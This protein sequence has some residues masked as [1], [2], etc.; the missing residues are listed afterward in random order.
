MVEGAASIFTDL[1]V[2]EACTIEALLK[3]A[4]GLVE[5]EGDAAMGMVEG[6]VLVGG[7]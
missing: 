7:I 3:V 5:V 4:I 6:A 2:G 1:E